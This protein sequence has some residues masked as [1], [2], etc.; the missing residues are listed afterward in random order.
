MR[1][2]KYFLRLTK[3]K[4]RLAFFVLQGAFYTIKYFT[5]VQLESHHAIGNSGKVRRPSD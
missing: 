5:I 2:A 4:M 3:F 1:L